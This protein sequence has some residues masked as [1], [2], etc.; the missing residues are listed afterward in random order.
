[1]SSERWDRINELFYAALE[2]PLEQRNI[3]LKESCGSDPSL[4]EEVESLLAAYCDSEDFIQLPA[5]KNA[6]EFLHQQEVKLES[7]ARIGAYKI[8]REVGRGGMGAVYLGVRADERFQKSVAIKVI[9]RG[10][11]TDDVLR[12]FRIEQQIL[13]NLDHPNIARLI[14]A[15]STESG[16]PYFIMEYVEGEPI[17]QYCDRLSL[18]ITERLQLFQQVCA[19]ISYAH[20]N[21]VIHRDIKPTNILVTAEGI[22]KLLDFGI[23]KILQSDPAER[24]TVTGMH[25]MTPEYASPEQ[26]QGLPV[27]TLSDVYSLG[28]LLYEILT[29]RFPYSFKN[30]SAVEILRAITETQPQ[31]PSE[32]I[33][34]PTGNSSNDSTESTLELVSRTREGT[35]EHL[36]SRLHGDID[37]IVMKAIRKEAEQRYASV[38]QFSEDIR[39]HLV[40]LPVIARPVTFSYRLSKFVR[41][42]KIAVALAGLIFLTLVGGII[43]TTRQSYR[44]EAERARAEKRFNDVRKLAHS[45]LFDY[46]DAIRDLPGST[47]IRARLVKDA[48]QYLDSLTSEENNDVSLQLELATAYERIGDVQGGTMKANLG[49]TPGSIQSYRKALVILQSLTRTDPQNKQT[50]YKIAVCLQ[51]LGALLWETGDLKGSLNESRKALMLLQ[52]LVAEDP[53]DFD[54]RFQLGVTL[55]RIGSILLEQNDFSGALESHQKELEIFQ[56]FSAAERESEKL[57]RATST[58]YEHIATVILS[59]GNYDKALEN[60]HRGLEIRQSLTKDFPL[61]ADYLR[62]LAVSYYWEGEILWKSGRTSEALENYQK[63][64]D[65][66]EK[67]FLKD[68]HNEVYRGDLAYGLNRVGD[69][70]FELGKTTEAITNFQRSQTLRAEDVKADPTNLWKR[71]ALIGTQSKICKALA[72]T[73]Q[74]EKAK[75]EC[76][77]TLSLMEKTKLEPTNAAD[78]SLF[79]DTYSDLGEAYSVLAMKKSTSLEGRQFACDMYKRSLEIWHDLQ[80]RGLLSNDNLRKIQLASSDLE[81]CNMS[82]ARN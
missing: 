61:N 70:Q 75:T 72:K 48:L 24:S 19:A 50:R 74:A 8:V 49:D 44:A 5:A 10:M 81:E 56:S 16:L 78:R 1:M 32:I 62:A 38:E 54:L 15:G 64:V 53:V 22:P 17:D 46:H 14:D 60:N 55:G 3:F 41:R 23:A 11:D 68:P 79:A 29:G 27:T 66:V 82:A 18:S 20:R 26:A 28:I 52:Q 40:G 65:I 67:L 4:Q 21:L 43:T 30:R 9:K 7:G 76:A 2:R 42:N 25:F 34:R 6:H 36:Q 57:R 47:P 80:S 73:G 31:L 45:V 71:T 35:L 77:V 63:D 59:M 13:G 69:L 12:H 39:R 37:N 58:A 33:K 51:K